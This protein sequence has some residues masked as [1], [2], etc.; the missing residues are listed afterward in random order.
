VV[1]TL[2]PFY[3]RVGITNRRKLQV[4]KDQ[5]IFSDWHASVLWS[6]V[7]TFDRCRAAGNHRFTLNK[8][9]LTRQVISFQ[10]V[11]IGFSKQWNATDNPP[12]CGLNTICQRYNIQNDEIASCDG[13]PTCSFSQDVFNFSQYAS[14]CPRSETGNRIWIYYSCINGNKNVCRPAA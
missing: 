2:C 5:A 14:P 1:Q 9:Q 12:Q 10:S 4:A 6:T 11:S 8:C 13:K 7:F 3:K